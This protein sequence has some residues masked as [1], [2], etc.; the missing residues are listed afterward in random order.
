LQLQNP[1]NSCQTMHMPLSS[2]D[3]DEM[4]TRIHSGVAAGSLESQTLD[5]KQTP[6]SRKEAVKM[7]VEACVCFA[8][9]H[10]G[11]VVV[12]VADATGGP[13]SFLGCDL[14][15]ATVQRRIYELTEPHLMAGVRAIERFGARLLVMDVVESFDLHADQ[16]GRATRRIGTDC[17]PLSPQDQ[18]RLREERLHVDWSAGAATRS[19]SDISPRA[20][21]AAREALSRL[22]DDRRPLAALSDVDL[23]RA[24]GVVDGDG[25][26][27]RAG[28]VLFCPP[29]T[30]AWVVYQ[31]RATPGGE[32]TAVDRIELPLV[33]AFE[34][35]MDLAWA[36]RTSTPLTLANGQQLDISDFP[37]SAIREALS[38]AVLHRDFQLAGAVQIEHSP[39]AMVVS[40]PGPLVGSVTSENIL[41]HVSTPR[42]ST[43]AKAARLL[44]MAEET[45]RGIDR[46]FREMARIGHDLPVID[47]GPDV[48][49]VVLSGG[50]PRTSVVRYVAQLP[51]E[52][53]EDT[54]AMLVLFT[55]CR[56]RTVSC[57]DIAPVL[58]KR[59]AEAEIALRRLSEDHP[60]MLEPTRESS[61]HRQP[62][63]RLRA[64]ALKAL[65]SA[66]Q[67][68]RRKVDETDRKIFDHIREYGR[69]T[70]RTLQNLFDIDVYRSRDILADMQRREL[71]IRTSEAERGPRVTYGSGPKFPKPGR[72][73]KP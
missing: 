13:G 21:T 37:E 30:G 7:L 14:D 54:D 18:R 61:R 15:P 71:I 16:Q 23:L 20:V 2:D 22:D 32:A 40:S 11:T 28:E 36:R 38:N 34:R 66:V 55:L 48:V 3:L 63:Y 46:M 42:N 47:D 31:Y 4:L 51:T 68:H 17:L 35:A 45:G 69:I 73:A 56:Q 72:A 59:P 26:L 49:R 25:R 65:G 50:A 12:G 24:L 52:E 27:L 64:D 39:T 62:I 10:G 19:F 33:L 57:I 9:A 43:L 60:G 44:R 70:N 58:Q 5:F 41:T 67:Y 53:Q 8:N 29:S 1:P 6:P